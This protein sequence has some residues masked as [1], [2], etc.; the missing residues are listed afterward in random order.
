MVASCSSV[1]RKLFWMLNH[2]TTN[3]VIKFRT[4]RASLIIAPIIYNYDEVNESEFLVYYKN[5]DFEE[6]RIRMR[7]I[8]KSKIMLRNLRLFFIWNRTFVV[9]KKWYFFHAREPEDGFD[10]IMYPLHLHRTLVF[11]IAIRSLANSFFFIVRPLL[12]RIRLL[13]N[14]VISTLILTS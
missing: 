2:L 4:N 14:D 10:T 3:Y 6:F 7:V 8:L 5:C 11:I 1:R 12:E 9:I 13:V